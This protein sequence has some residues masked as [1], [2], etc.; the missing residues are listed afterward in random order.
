MIASSWRLAAALLLSSA[1]LTQAATHDVVVQ[2]GGAQEAHVIFTF[3]QRTGP[4]RL[5]L[6]TS[7]AGVAGSRLAVSV[8]GGAPVIDHILTPDECKFVDDGSR[9]EVVIAGD[10]PAYAAVTHAFRTGRAA[11]VTIEDAGAMKMDHPLSLR[12]LGRALRS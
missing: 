6:R 5:V 2:A 8:D 7:V 12:G 10:D 4:R 1:P 9:C 3:D 11:R